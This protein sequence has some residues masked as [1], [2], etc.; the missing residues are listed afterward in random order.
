M[1]YVGI[2]RDKKS[3]DY[4]VYEGAKNHAIRVSGAFHRVKGKF[5]LGK[6]AHL[7]RE[8][9]PNSIAIAQFFGLIAD[10]NRSDEITDKPAISRPAERTSAC[11]PPRAIFAK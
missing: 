8:L 7:D 11:L 2:A 9:W 1:A 3:H 6:I 4:D 5:G 10:L